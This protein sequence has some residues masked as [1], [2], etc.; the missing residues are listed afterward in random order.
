MNRLKAFLS[1]SAKHFRF[2]V[3]AL[4]MSWMSSA[5][6]LGQ[7][8]G[9][10]N[11]L[12]RALKRFPDA[13]ADKDGKLSIA[14]ARQ[15]L[16]KHP[17]LKTTLGAKLDEGSDTKPD[18]LS[19]PSGTT[20]SADMPIGP[21]VFVCAHSFMIFTA[22]LLPPMVEA[23][24]IGYRD[25]GKQMI[26]GSRVIQ[27]WDLPDEKNKAKEALREGNV[28]VLTLSPHSLIPDEGIDNFVRLGI[29]KN[30]KLR[31]LIQAS[32]PARDGEAT[33][34]FTNEKRNEL[35]EEGL[36]RMKENH[37]ATWVKSI[38]AQVNSLN[39]SIGHNAV[40]II[41]VCDAVFAL[42]GHILKGTAPGLTKQTDLFRDP[43]GHPNPPL[44]A[45]V[46]YCHFS[47]IYQRTP[48]GLPVPASLKANPKAD[49]LNL[50]LQQLAWE[51]IRQ[52]P[53]SGVKVD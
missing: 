8:S 47:A 13:D 11:R 35:T 39:T 29:E 51:A 53:M 37:H 32:W 22:T 49:E 46:T 25:A 14:E 34:G 12:N 7:D 26:G 31:V 18:S 6:L 3:F 24:H 1:Y 43:L 30:P 4:V 27:H 42:R 40:A 23:A 52:Y 9:I 28:D 2:S 33:N 21:R 16:A 38:E 50:M 10:E 20:G 48:V 5:C 45:L 17:E 36:R 19:S 15:Y 44:A 41:P